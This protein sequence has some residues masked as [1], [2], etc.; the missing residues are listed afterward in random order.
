[1]ANSVGTQ[2]QQTIEEDFERLQA[3][4][5]CRSHTSQFATFLVA[6]TACFDRMNTNFRLKTVLLTRSGSC[7]T[8]SF[9]QR[10]SFFVGLPQASCIPYTRILNLLR[11]VHLLTLRTHRQCVKKIRTIK[12]AI[13]LLH[14]GEFG[15]PSIQLYCLLQF[16]M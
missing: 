2:C 14:R 3:T 11:A 8:Q 13:R 6:I 10:R 1:M 4:Q 5:E 7:Y 15:I 9:Q 12:R 16:S